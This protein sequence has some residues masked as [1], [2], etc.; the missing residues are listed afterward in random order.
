MLDKKITFDS[1]IRA[2]MGVLIGVIILMILNRLS[3]VLLPFFV[4]W[5]IAYLIFPMVQFFQYRCKMKY[6]VLA[7]I[8]AILVV[9]IIG[10]GIF[11]LII[12]PMVTEA[13][14]IKDLLIEYFESSPSDGVPA[15]IHSYILQHLN[16]EQIKALF[17]RQ[18]FLNALREYLPKLWNVVIESV[19]VVFSFFSVLMILLYT[20]FILLDYESISEGWVN[21][22]PKRFRP[23]CIKL[24]G[25]VKESMN[26]YFRGQAMVATCVGI[27]FSIGFLIIDFPLAIGLGLFIGILNM[28]PY[29][30]ILG[31][32]P[33][34]ILAILK[35]A[36]TGGNFWLI[37]LS[38]FAVFAIV[39]AIQDGFL[40]PRI[41][42][43]VTGLSPAII[44]LSLSIWGSLMGVMG[45]IIALPIT[46]L[47]ISYYQK[48]VI[49]RE[50]IKNRDI[51]SDS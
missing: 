39:Q 28:V 31:F 2:A 40:T 15:L 14:R 19:N 7:I 50:H 51:S 24:V 23:I 32:I 5:L 47:L 35:A 8:C 48:Y 46:A 9:T 41:M 13:W 16:M 42:G 12:P 4:A 30:Q 21:L 38:A 29:L 36:D 44:L 1:F 27:L 43:K 18:D 6:R 3:N 33:T 26:K 20:I 10:L 11:Y 49:N 34:I 17:S 45:M 37:L 22:V 25:D